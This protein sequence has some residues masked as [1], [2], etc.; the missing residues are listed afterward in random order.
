MNT[1]TIAVIVGLLALGAVVFFR[2]TNYKGANK[3]PF[4]FGDAHDGNFPSLLTSNGAR[5][6]GVDKIWLGLAATVENDSKQVDVDEA[7]D[8]VKLDV[9]SCS[10]SQAYFFVHLKDFGEASGT[11]YLNLY[12]DW[13]ND[14]KWSGSDACASEWAVRNFPIDLSKQNQEVAL[15]APEFT[16]GKNTQ[17]FWYRGIVS[18]NQ[19]MNETATGEFESGEVEDYSKEPEDEKYYGAYCDPAPLEIKHGDKGDIKVLPILFSEPINKVEFGQ[20]YNPKTDKRKVSIQNNIVTYESSQKDVDPPKR[21]DRHLVDLKASFG[22]AGVEAV[23]EGS[24]VVDVE[25]DEITKI[26]VGKTPP[27]PPDHPSTKTE[28]VPPQSEPHIQEKTPGLM[29]Y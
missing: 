14:G 23:L 5:A 11:A 9:R 18:L 29:G 4:D 8:G 25:H 10:A 1:K 13:N 6:K 3:I 22:A 19:Q 26:P 15:Y 2:I 21:F 28:S 17:D 12:A 7:D 16:A 27:L 24:C 20:N